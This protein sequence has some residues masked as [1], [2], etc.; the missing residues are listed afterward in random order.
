M[1]IALDEL[2]LEQLAMRQRLHVLLE[3]HGEKLE[4]QIELILLHKHIH[5]RDDIRVLQLSQ[6]R[7]LANR[8]A[9][10]AFLVILEP[11]LLQRDQLVRDL[12][13]AFI[14][15]TISAFADLLNLNVVREC[16]LLLWLL[17]KRLWSCNS[18]FYFHLCSNIAYLLWEFTFLVIRIWGYLDSFFHIV[19]INIDR[20]YYY[21]LTYFKYFRFS[22]TII[23][24]TN[25]Q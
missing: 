23:S 15:H 8:C 21:Y 18:R 20:C 1:K 25:G 19:Y 2:C 9:R 13:L 10:H 16:E 17:L 3:I 14:H 7:N 5:E 22:H 12:V 24:W 11:N 6:K 4:H